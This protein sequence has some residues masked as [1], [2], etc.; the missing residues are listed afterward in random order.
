MR[1]RTFSKQ[2]PRTCV[3]STQSA[4]AA[5][6]KASLDLNSRLSSWILD[7][8]GS[9]YVTRA[10]LRS[11]STMISSAGDFPNVVDV[12]FVGYPKHMYMRPL[13]RLRCFIERGLNR[14][15]NKMGHL[16][17]DV[18]GQF[19]KTCFDA[20]LLAFPGEI[21]GSKGMQYPPKPGPG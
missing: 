15:D 19:N 14:I 17:V 20:V 6:V 8:W 11:S 7:T 12:S 18:S 16:P 1:R 9:L 13:Q 4:S 5:I 10:R 21:K 3:P 2:T